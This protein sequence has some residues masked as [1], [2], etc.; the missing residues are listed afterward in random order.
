MLVKAIETIRMKI[1]RVGMGNK[2]T[3]SIYRH[4]DKWDKN[5]CL[6]TDSE[7]VL[8]TKCT[9]GDMAVHTRSC[10]WDSQS[11]DCPACQAKKNR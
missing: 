9:G 3:L 4:K 2:S 6:G 8:W 10:K 11:L 7:S 5:R 1:W